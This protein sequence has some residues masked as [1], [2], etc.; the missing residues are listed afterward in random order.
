MVAAQLGVRPGLD[1]ALHGHGRGRLARLAPPRRSVTGPALA[2]YGV[3]LV[4]NLL[5]TPVFFG[6]YPAL[7]TPAL[8][9][10]VRHHHRPGRGRRRHRAVLRADQPHRRAADAALPVLGRVRRQS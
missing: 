10:G 1:R 8:W 6:L 2:A 5:W 9:L 7:G 3:Q 4:L